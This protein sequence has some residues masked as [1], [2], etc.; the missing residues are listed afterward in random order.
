MLALFLLQVTYYNVIISRAGKVEVKLH[1][2]QIEQIDRNMVQ[3]QTEID[4]LTYQ[5]QE[6]EEKVK[7]MEQHLRKQKA[8]DDGTDPVYSYTYS[9]QCESDE[10]E[11]IRLQAEGISTEMCI[12][13][14][15]SQKHEML[16]ERKVRTQEVISIQKELSGKNV[17]IAQNLP[18]HTHYY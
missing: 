18:A 2:S 10:L 11:L 6:L 15:S 16:C 3:K 8:G 4:F 1:L 14:A 7:K 12:F 9:S 17:S 13:V 5:R